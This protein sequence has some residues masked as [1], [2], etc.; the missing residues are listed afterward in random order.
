MDTRTG[1]KLAAFLLALAVICCAP[2]EVKKKGKHTRTNITVLLDLSDRI[3]K[4]PDQISRD[5]E[6][7]EEVYSIFVELQ[8]NQLYINSEDVFRLRIAPQLNQFSN[9]DETFKF[10]DTLSVDMGTIP[11]PQK[12]NIADSKKSFKVGLTN[13]YEQAKVSSDPNDYLGADVPRYLNEFYASEMCQDSLCN[14]F[15]V[16][17]TDGYLFVDGKSEALDKWQNLND[18]TGV[19]VLVLEMNPVD[20]QYNSM[21]RR[22][23]DWLGSSNAQLLKLSQKRG[24]KEIQREL[25]SFFGIELQKTPSQPGSTAELG[26][27]QGEPDVAN[28][29]TGSVASR[30][31]EGTYHFNS[32]Q[33]LRT[34]KLESSSEDKYLCSIIQ[35]GQRYHNLDGKYDED[36]TILLINGLG[37][38]KVI[39]E[40]DAVV[41]ISTEGQNRFVRKL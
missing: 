31:L 36:K 25:D 11:I 40:E 5:I 21:K 37:S 28:F 7:I 32:E 17:L 8:R 29:D 15:L 13:L 34:L 19:K 38:F 10:E 23:Q 3:I 18:L 4:S 33:Q 30:T 22:W 9:E 35:L 12:K 20:G 16:I 26:D 2:P 1:I 27:V 24:V 39:F 6:L 41:L 14:D